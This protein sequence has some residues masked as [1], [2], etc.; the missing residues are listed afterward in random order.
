MT[1]FDLISFAKLFSR[2]ASGNMTMSDAE[3]EAA[4]KVLKELGDSA[5]NWNPAQKELYKAMVDTA[6]ERSKGAQNG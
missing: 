6:K 4:T 2:V 1:L 5:P 3:M